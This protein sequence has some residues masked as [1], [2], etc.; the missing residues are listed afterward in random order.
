MKT[1]PTVLLTFAA[2]FALL[3]NVSEAASTSRPN[4][5]FIAID[6]MNDW[7]TV[8]DPDNPIK[9]P[10]L[11]RL[12]KRGCFFSKAYCAAPGCNPSRTALLTGL[13]PTTSGVYT[14]GHPWRKALPD[15][16]TLPKYFENHGYATRGAGKIF[17]HGATGAEDPD[18]PSFQEFF[19]MP[20][21]RKTGPN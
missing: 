8:F 21:A 14:N 4:V 12:A 1:T 6:D 5:L 9:T 17:H 13:L 7:S 19:K 2:A 15:A 20:R 3:S 10:N 18:N 11:E 16:V